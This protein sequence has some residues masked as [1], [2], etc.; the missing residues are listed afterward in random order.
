M[1]KKKIEIKKEYLEKVLNDNNKFCKW[2]LNK[3]RR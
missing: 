1:A 3:K 2:K